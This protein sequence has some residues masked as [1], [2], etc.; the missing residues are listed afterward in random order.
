M[1]LEFKGLQVHRVED[2]H[3]TRRFGATPGLRI[4]LKLHPSVDDIHP[5]LP[6]NKEKTRISIV[7]GVLKVIPKPNTLQ[8]N[9]HKFWGVP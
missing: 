6:I 9:A 2:L 8:L 3:Y 1:G 4:R 5:A 7:F